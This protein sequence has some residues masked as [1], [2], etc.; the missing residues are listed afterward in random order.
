MTSIELEFIKTLTHINKKTLE[1]K[2]KLG[3]MR[4]MCDSC[5]LGVSKHNN[6]LYIDKPSM[7]QGVS[8]WFYGQNRVVIIQYLYKELMESDGLISLVKTLRD[9]CSELFMYCPTS[10]INTAST[11][12]SSLSVY[13]V[14]QYHTLSV[15]NNTRKLFKVLCTENVELLKIIAHGLSKLYVTY[16]VDDPRYDS[17]D[18]MVQVPYFYDH[19]E[20]SLT[21][22]V[23]KYIQEMQKRVKFERVMLESVLEK[24]NTIDIA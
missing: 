13:G 18:D 10:K 8:R 2:H 22:R 15:S 5:K 12:L 11:S 14:H 1:F 6:V 24:F 9:K 23:I 16:E 17:S 20:C 21:E 4:D 7:F 3:V 19:R